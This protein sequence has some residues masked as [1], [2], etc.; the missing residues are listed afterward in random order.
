MEKRRKGDL[1]DYGIYSAEGGSKPKF[2]FDF[3]GTYYFFQKN[4]NVNQRVLLAQSET[5]YSKTN[6]VADIPILKKFK[7]GVN[8]S[9]NYLDG[10]ANV[11]FGNNRIDHS[12]SELSD[13]DEGR[14]ATN[15]IFTRKRIS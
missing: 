7:H 6:T 13:N 3:G 11:Y 14:T 15:K 10:Q 8:L 4:K 9:F 1:A 12:L 2:M 5:A